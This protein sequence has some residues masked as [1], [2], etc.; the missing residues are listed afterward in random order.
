M[1]E[2][3]KKSILKYGKTAAL[4]IV[5]ILSV[6]SLIFTNV[7]VNTIKETLINKLCDNTTGLI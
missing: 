7:T 2:R 5:G 4:V 6:Y 1:D 3:I